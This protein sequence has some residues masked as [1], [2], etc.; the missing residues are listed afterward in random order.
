MLS[1]PES[2]W[3]QSEHL[4]RQLTQRYHVLR[5]L[6]YALT[7]RKKNRE[8]LEH[9]RDMACLDYLELYKSFAALYESIN[10]RPVTII[11]LHIYY[12]NVN[13]IKLEK[14]YPHKKIYEVLNHLCPNHLLAEV[15]TFPTI[16]VRIIIIP[17]ILS[18][19][20]QY[21]SNPYLDMYKDNKRN[22]P[23]IEKYNKYRYLNSELA[24]NDIPKFYN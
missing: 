10:A 22:E 3:R 14:R 7:R 20:T 8:T 15:K 21:E 19:R 6:N 2:L 11:N 17:P 24:I 23:K 16:V 1:E 12:E 13:K 4:H 18:E 9:Q 5:K